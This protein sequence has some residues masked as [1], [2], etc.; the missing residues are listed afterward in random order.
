[1]KKFIL[2]TLSSLLPIAIIAV[3]MEVMLR[4]I[5][6]DYELKRKYLDS[7]SREIETLILGSSHSFFGLDPAYFSVNTFN[8]GYN[9]QSLDYDYEILKKY[10][11]KFDK[12][13]TLVLPVS[14]FTLFGKL[15][16]G[17]DRWLIKNYILYF[18][19]NTSPK[20]SDHTE[21]LSNKLN[22]NVRRLVSYYIKGKTNS[23]SS[24]LGWGTTYN[25]EN[26]R[27][28]TETGKESALRHTRKD[29]ESGKNSQIYEENILEINN[30]INWCNDRHVV[31][32]LFTPP[33]FETYRRH[34]NTEQL[35]I[36]LKTVNEFDV[37]HD[38]CIYINLL[39]DPQFVAGD[40]YDSDHLSEIGAKKLSKIFDDRITEIE[41]EIRLAGLNIIDKPHIMT[42]QNISIS[43][44]H[45]LQP[46]IISW[47][48]VKSHLITQSGTVNMVT[49]Y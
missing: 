14:Y 30:I 48:W 47:D 17:P 27:D 49:R 44:D 23:I 15:E 45:S 29:I 11:D 28:L 41:N 5:P 12:L 35:N 34:L 25:S 21:I 9:S 18:R 3:L 42:F 24:G 8:A 19:I 31:V 38:N 46:V 16:T 39:S 32:I 13:K 10:Q 1:M 6:N 7:H 37:K 26:A 40:F 20:F 22:V 43:R 2:K 36:T 33:A 4:L